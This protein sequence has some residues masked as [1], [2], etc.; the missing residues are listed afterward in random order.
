MVHHEIAI[1]LGTYAG[2][3]SPEPSI[4][5]WMV[6]HTTNI[7]YGRLNQWQWEAVGYITANDVLRICRALVGFFS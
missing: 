4:Q 7:G 5:K 1:E 6:G 2:G 3:L